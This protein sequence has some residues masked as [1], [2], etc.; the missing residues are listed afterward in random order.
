MSFLQGGEDSDHKKTSEFTSAQNDKV[1]ITI[2]AIKNEL[3]GINDA[4]FK[5]IQ[6]PD[7]LVTIIYFSS[8]IEK[9]TLHRTV[10]S[11]LL[12]KKLDFLKS[13][14]IPVNVN[15]SDI[16]SSIAE[17]NTVVYFHTK[18]IFAT[19]NTYSAPT[20]SIINSDTES[21]VSGPRDS[22]TES[23][24]TNLSLVKRRIQNTGLKTRDFTIGTE[25]NT[26]VSVMY[27]EKIVNEENLTK[28]INKIETV[29]YRGFEDISILAQL[30]EDHPFSPFPQYQIT[31][32]PDL[33]AS[34]LIDGRVIIMMNNSI[35][36][37]ICP[38]SFLGFFMSPEDYY[39]RWTTATLL[40]CIRFF[41]FFL[42][43]MLTPFYI[44]ALS[45]H[46]EILP[47]EVLKSIHESR[48]RVPFPPV[49]EVLFMELVIEVL[50]EAGSRM[51]TKIGQTIGIVGG[52]VIGTAAVEA[53][54]V[55][56]ILIVLVAISAL[57]SFLPPSF[58][59]SNASR[60]VRYI[61]I[62]SAG[63]FGLYGQMIAFA[64]LI[65]HLVNLT[66]LGSPYM[67]PVIPRKWTDLLDSIILTPTAFQKHK[68]GISG[69]ERKKVLPE[70]GEE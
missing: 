22:F 17:G 14:E 48:S 7:D 57:L 64:W 31:E 23:L 10:I 46:P 59:M 53:G 62:L 6:T 2:T 34:S 13:A 33:V 30:M 15:L 4:V 51:P 8:L 39:N 21:T 9:L 29:D 35:G 16:L 36:T 69:T 44:S 32:R 56:N 26:K 19:V 67:S 25:T 11:P 66:S 37:M 40:R 43:I 5:D 61:F 63:L 68:K 52:I 50:R 70:E 18:N 58:K 54:L 27:M 3:A 49:I 1:L 28:V 20:G 41:G 55:S 60:F 38:S 45:Y 65:F 47:Y 24:Q 42:T 12:D